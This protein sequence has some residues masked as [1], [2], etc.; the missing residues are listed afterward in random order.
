MADA[1]VEARDLVVA[2]GPAILGCCYEVGDEV[3]EAL[4]ATCGA[5]SGFAARARS[6][7]TAVD[8]H[9]ALRRQLLDAGVPPESI[10]A[11]PWCTRCRL[12]MF[13]SYRAEGPGG[14]R[15]LAVVGPAFGP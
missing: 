14:G 6:G 15:Q 1:G 11:A 2:L 9:A 8:L 13:F 10:L 3:A 4:S 12:D 7:R 5:P